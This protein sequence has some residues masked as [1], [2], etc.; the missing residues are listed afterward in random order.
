MIFNQNLLVVL[1][2]YN[3]DIDSNNIKH[4]AI[5]IEVEVVRGS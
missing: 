1:G 2:P 4:E 5:A 3:S